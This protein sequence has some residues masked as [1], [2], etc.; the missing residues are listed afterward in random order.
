MTRAAGR[1][2]GVLAVAAF[3]VATVL[4]LIAALF[5]EVMIAWHDPVMFVGIL[6]LVGAGYG[7]MRFWD[8]HRRL[9][10]PPPDDRYDGDIGVRVPVEP[11]PP[12]RVGYAQREQRR[13]SM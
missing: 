1:A 5:L 2:I 4:L 13:R 7:A 11:P 3:L 9:P 6:A 12:V 10:P 8:R